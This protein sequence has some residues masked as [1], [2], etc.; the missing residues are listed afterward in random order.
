MIDSSCFEHE[1]KRNKSDL[2][3]LCTPIYRVLNTFETLNLQ[4]GWNKIRIGY[5]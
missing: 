4:M 5:V 1:P 3:F 2:A